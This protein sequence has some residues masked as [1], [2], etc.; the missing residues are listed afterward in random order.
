MKYIDKKTHEHQALQLIDS[1][2]RPRWVDA[3]KAF[4]NISYDDLRDK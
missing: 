2:M 1:F 3:N 4:T